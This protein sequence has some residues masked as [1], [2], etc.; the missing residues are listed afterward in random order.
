[1]FLH[2][3]SMAGRLLGKLTR[4]RRRR[5]WMEGL[6]IGSDAGGKAAA[7]KQQNRWRHKEI[8]IENYFLLEILRITRVIIL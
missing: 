2:S 4:C 1:M 8:V 7:F 3:S 5:W 6:G